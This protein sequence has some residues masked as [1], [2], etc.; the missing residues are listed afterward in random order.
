MLWHIEGR[1]Q[2]ATKHPAAPGWSQRQRARLTA[3]WGESS[4]LWEGSQPAPPRGVWPL[5]GY[6]GGCSCRRSPAELPGQGGGTARRTR[7]SHRPGRPSLGSQRWREDAPPHHQ[8]WPLGSGFVGH[9]QPS[10]GTCLLP[11]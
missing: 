3:P 5:S 11:S 4:L 7:L 10:S 8:A 2:D 1:G 6:A 9:S